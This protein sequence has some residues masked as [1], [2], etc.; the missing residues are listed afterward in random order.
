MISF[1]VPGP[2]LS[3]HMTC[4]RFLQAHLCPRFKPT[5]ARSQAATLC[6]KT[7]ISF[8]SLLVGKIESN[9]MSGREVTLNIKK[10]PTMF[11]WFRKT[12]HTLGLYCADQGLSTIGKK[13]D[14]ID[15]LPQVASWKMT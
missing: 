9:K 13:A 4:T 6:T 12:K 5:F 2:P 8:F 3:H 10:K 14:L 15:R 7:R 11:K 1:L